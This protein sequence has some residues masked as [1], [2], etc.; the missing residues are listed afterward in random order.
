MGVAAADVAGV[1]FHG[2]ELE[3][4]AAQNARIAVAH[5]G[6]GGVETGLI[7]VVGIAVL[8]GELAG[9]H[10][11]ETRADLVA[12]LG[13]DLVEVAG[14][15]P[16]ALHL[17]TEEIGDH[18]FVRWTQAE[19]PFMAVL[20]A[21]HFRAHLRPAAGFLPQLRRL[22]HWQQHFL[23]TAGVEFFAD[24][25]LD[26]ADDP[27]PQGQPAV[28]PGSDLADQTGPQH[29]LMTDDVRTGGLFLQRGDQ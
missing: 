28:E 27:Q 21:Q 16:V 17:P 22:H 3:R 15:L 19:V 2:A 20:H 23:S 1:G 25:G 18:L 11:A 5:L 7:Q 10:D 13:L 14:K 8:H 24:D 9:P 26:L 4:H 6:V 29:E 12:K